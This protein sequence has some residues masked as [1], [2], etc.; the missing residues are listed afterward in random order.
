MQAKIIKVE[1]SLQDL[2]K[3]NFET[4]ALTVISRAEPQEMQKLIEGISEIEKVQVFVLDEMCIRDRF[5]A[6]CTR[7]ISSDQY[8]IICRRDR[9]LSQFIRC[10]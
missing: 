1:P 6:G 5:A 9:I 8:F 3:E 7:F 2:E 4:F 10:V